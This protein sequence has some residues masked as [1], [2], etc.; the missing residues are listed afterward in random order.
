MSF[1]AG[2]Y[3]AVYN[4]LD[5]GITEDGFDLDITF[6]QESIRGDNLGSAHQDHVYR[7]ANAFASW[8]G[9]EWDKAGMAQ[10][11]YPWAAFGVTGQVGR[12][13]T[14]V[15]DTLLLTVVAGTTADTSGPNTLTALKS[16]LSAD[17]NVKHILST[18]HRK[19]PL[20][21]QFYPYGSQAATATW[22]TVT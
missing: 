1:V 12:L 2:P 17:F 16:I 6:F 11:Y 8:V 9:Q 10:A 15:A 14:N 13:A 21:H 7:A 19:V 5:L 4:D 18:R 20:R 22:F 3:T